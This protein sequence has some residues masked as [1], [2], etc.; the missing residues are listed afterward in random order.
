MG[1]GQRKQRISQG[2]G[3]VKNGDKTREELLNEMMELRQRNVELEK[4]EFQCRQVKNKLRDSEKMYRT[5]YDENPSMYFT[6]DAGGVVISINNFGAEQLGYK[7]GELV[8]QSVMKVIYE[9]D[10]KPL[11]QQIAECLQ[12]PG[13]IATK[14]LRKVRKDGSLLWVKEVARAV[15]AVEG[16]IVLIVCKDI[17]E[18]KRAEEELR[19][20]EARYQDLVENA[21]D[22]IF[23]LSLDRRITFLNPAFETITGWRREEWLDRDFMLLI[24][25]DDLNITQ[26]VPNL[27]SINPKKSK[28]QQ[29]NS[30]HI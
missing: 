9:D 15:N 23:S 13:H 11:F 3:T 25:P 12:E 1:T 18:R 14:E 10:K 4:S 21:R 20:S 26:A 16:N 24:H 7:V 8:G 19:K 17:T 5:L 30:L 28:Y 22:V 2:G 27:T 29:K 6:V